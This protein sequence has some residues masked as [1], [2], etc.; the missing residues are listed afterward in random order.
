LELKAFIKES[1]VEV[2]QAIHEANAEIED[3]PFM[4]RR[5][6]EGKTTGIEFDV[7]VTTKETSGVKGGITVWG[8]G[9]GG[10]AEDANEKVSHIRFTV[11]IR[12]HVV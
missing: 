9:I 6:Q 12:D 8:L 5:T 3:G 11:M 10:N 2:G 7:A 1:L 4:L